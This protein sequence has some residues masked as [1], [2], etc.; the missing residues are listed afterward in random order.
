MEHIITL[1]INLNRI[2]GYNKI[3]KDIHFVLWFMYSFP[4]GILYRFVDKEYIC[5][6][7]SIYM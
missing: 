6:N 4:N 3:L 2:G 5:K 7:V 1:Y